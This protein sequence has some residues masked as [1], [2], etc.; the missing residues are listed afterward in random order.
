MTT[1]SKGELVPCGVSASRCPLEEAQRQQC[2]M[3]AMT[4]P[5]ALER[6]ETLPKILML[7]M[8]YVQLRNYKVGHIKIFTSSFNVVQGVCEKVVIFILNFVNKK[9]FE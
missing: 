4:V 1:S 3:R 5:F 9:I 6:D 7:L 2:Q 8:S